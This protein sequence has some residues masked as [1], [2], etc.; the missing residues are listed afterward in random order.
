MANQVLPAGPMPPRHKTFA[1]F[2][3]DTTLDPNQG[4]YQRVLARFDPET[5]NIPHAQ[6]LEQVIGSGPVPQAYLCC[7]LNAQCVRIHCIHLPTKFTSALNGEVTPWDGNVYA[8]LGESTHGTVTTVNVPTDP[9]RR[10]ANIQVKTNEYMVTHLDELT[11]LGFPAVTINEPDTT[12]IST[13]QLMYL[14]AR[15]VPLLL[16]PAG[17]SLRQVWE[18]LYPS[19]V[20]NNDLQP[21]APLL[22]WLCVASTST[23][24]ARNVIGPSV[25]AMELMAPL[26]DQ[27]LIKHRMQLLA[28]VLPALYQ[29][30]QSLENVLAQMAAAVVQNTNDNWVAREEKAAQDQ[31][32]KL[33]SEKYTLTLGILQEYLEIADERDL[34]QLWHNWA[35]CKKRQ[36]FQVLAEQLQAYTCSPEAYSAN[37]P[38]VTSKLVQDLQNFIFVGDSMDDLKTGLQPFIIAEGSAEHRQANL[39][40]SHTYGLLQSGE[41]SLMLADL[42]ALQARE[43]ASIPLTYF[44]LERNLGMFGTLLGTVLGNQHII[45]VTYRQFWDLLNRGFRNELQQIIDLKGYVKP[46]HILRSIHLACYSWFTQHRHRLA[47]PTPDFVSILHNITLN[48]Y[49]LL[50]LPPQL[51]KL[52]YPKLVPHNTQLSL[53]TPTTGALTDTSSIV[54]A[55]TSVTAG[56]ST[57]TGLWQ[58]VPVKRARG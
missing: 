24:G 42:E 39:E 20:A 22:N 44:E 58:R 4:D 38:I 47:P 8:Y 18:I 49:T 30:D 32:P 9:F 15:Y 28:Q 6:L 35:N 41:Q 26:A 16:D 29:P 53:N 51:Y 48:T 2:Y 57:L 36:E 13:R 27:V 21:C 1:S 31:T 52:A 55:L 17:Y 10:I 54:S 50:R 25:V 45:S 14:S 43:V 23:V 5:N 3:A 19:L 7:V 33:P 12:V 37:T 34:P 46:A 11:P 56:R 40:I